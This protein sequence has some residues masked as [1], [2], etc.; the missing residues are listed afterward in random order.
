MLYPRVRPPQE[1]PWH[2]A[3]RYGSVR[4]RGHALCA[5]CK[6][7]VKSDLAG[8]RNEHDDALLQR[9]AEMGGTK[10]T[11]LADRGFGD[12]S[13]YEL[14][15]DQLGF[16]FVVRFRGVVKVT[17]AEGEVKAA[18]DWVPGNGRPLLLRKARD[19][20]KARGRRRRVRE[21][22]GRPASASRRRAATTGDRRELYPASA[23]VAITP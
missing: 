1:A 10:V 20:D 18:K 14:F 7:V 6:S 11:V 3:P 2:E 15:A 22:Q 8:W 21:G 9:L 23:T 4:K 12:Q 17:N 13:L 19:Q 16:D 5:L